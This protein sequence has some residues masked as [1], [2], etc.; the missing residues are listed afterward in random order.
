MPRSLQSIVDACEQSPTITPNRAAAILRNANVAESDLMPWAEFDH[1]TR[2]G[3]GRRAVKLGSNYELMIMSWRP[4]DFSAIHD[5][6]QT[7]WGAVMVF[8]QAEHAVYDLDGIRLTTRERVQTTHG[9][10]NVVDHDLIHQMGNS[11]NQRFFSL[12]LYGCQQAVDGVTGD[13]RI[14][15]LFQNQ[16][17]YTSGGVFYCLPADKINRHGTSVIGDRET[18]TTHHQQMLDRI[19]RVQAARRQRDPRLE[20]IA[21]ELRLSLARLEIHADVAA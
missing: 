14:F 16:I 10:I 4:G 9:Q 18:T 5:H 20:K 12:H 7:Q 2:D 19:V 3:Y 13:A 11:T 15:D 21:S 8:G 17:Q 1:P 6:G